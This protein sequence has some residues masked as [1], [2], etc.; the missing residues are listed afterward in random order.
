MD[1]A[2]EYRNNI[3]NAKISGLPDTLGITNTE[4]NTCLMIF[5]VGCTYLDIML[6]TADPGRCPDPGS[7]EHPY[8][9]GQ[10]LALYRRSH[11]SL[12]D[13]LPVPGL[14]QKLRWTVHVPVHPRSCRRPFSARGVFAPVVLV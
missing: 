6:G 14:H 7:I 2:H 1:R 11:R 4:Y 5:Y 8:L 3:A 10:A 12:G 13:C 9:E